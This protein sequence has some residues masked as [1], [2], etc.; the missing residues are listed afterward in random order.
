MEWGG[1]DVVGDVL[2]WIEISWCNEI[3]NY[4]GRRLFCIDFGE[5]RV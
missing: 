4:F 2:E 1:L 5:V 3:V